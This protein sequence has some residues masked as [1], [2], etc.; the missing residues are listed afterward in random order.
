MSRLFSRIILV[1]LVWSAL[2]LARPAR[3][4][5]PEL[6]AHAKP[7]VVLLTITDASGK[8][9]ATGTGFFVSAE[10]RIITNHHVIEDA[11]RVTATLAEG[12]EVRILGVLAMD[13]ARDIAV[14]QAEGTGFV[15][16]QLGESIHMRP[17]DD[18]AVLGSPHGLSGTLSTGIISAMRDGGPESDMPSHDKHDPSSWAIQITAGMAPGSSGSPIMNKGGEVIA[19]AVGQYRNSQNLNFGVPIEVA[20]TL[21]AGIPPNAKPVPFASPPKSPLLRNLGISF[22]VFVVLVVGYVIIGRREARRP[23]ARTR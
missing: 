11:Q 23:R 16:L 3:A 22:A 5:L 4:D 7:S 8:K 1:A 10:G 18:V 14:I 21:L 2:L 15:P 13:E 9:I 12:K 17:G 19:V 6:A 20:K